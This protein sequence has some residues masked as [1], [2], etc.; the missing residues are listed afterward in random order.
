MDER[1]IYDGFE[2]VW[3]LFE[4]TDQEIR[5]LRLS[6]QETDKQIQQMSLETDRK[7]QETDRKFQ[8]TDKQIQRISRD[9]G[10]LGGRWGEFVE[11]MVKPAVVRLFQ[12]RGLTTI[13]HFTMIYSGLL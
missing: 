5:E 11:S 7:F 8:E 1:V 4:K 12:Q 9:I 2:R 3:R 6:F 10:R 13:T